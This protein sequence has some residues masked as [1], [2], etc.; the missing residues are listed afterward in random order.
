MNEPVTF[1]YYG[2]SEP[3]IVRDVH[4]VMLYRVEGYTGAYFTAY[5]QV[6]QEIRT[7]RLDRVQL[8]PPARALDSET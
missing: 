1:T 7:F 8:P 5:Y 2:D 3:G 4:P 6:R